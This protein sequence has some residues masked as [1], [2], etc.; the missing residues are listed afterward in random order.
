MDE[1]P[2]CHVLSG[3]LNETPECQGIC[4]AAECPSYID[5][6]TPKGCLIAHTTLTLI[7]MQRISHCFKA[8]I[9]NLFLFTTMQKD[10]RQSDDMWSILL[11]SS[12][13]HDVGKLA[14]EYVFRS[15]R[16][17]HITHHQVSAII[18]RRVLEKFSN[19]HIALVL[20]Y[21]ILFHHE[22]ID[23][24]AIEQSLFLFSYL[25]RVFSPIQRV[26]YHV[27]PTRL[28][29]FRKNLHRIIE[30]S[31]R[32]NIISQ[33]Q[34]QVLTWTLESIVQELISNQKSALYV[35]QDLEVTR[36]QD[37]RYLTPALA[38]YRLLYLADNRAASARS[39]YWLESLQKVDWHR[40]EDVA[41][42]IHNLLARRY[43][44][45]G[46]S[47]IPGTI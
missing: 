24:K 7:E 11:A 5:N 32:K 41:Q 25:Q 39:Q 35:S 34:Y 28:E 20:A 27:N 43:H 8:S 40:L 37:P 12:L 19:K 13:L 36:T 21:A 4:S 18:A 23:W 17:F 42:Q 2:E 47:T 9:R 29:K 14:E 10:F 16:Q 15:T 6:L 31:Y 45:I 1:I 30:Q 33:M 22:A 3:I 38:I 44:Y 46:F 26:T